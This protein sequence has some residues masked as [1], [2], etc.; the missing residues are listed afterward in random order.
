M[1]ALSVMAGSFYCLTNGMGWL[2]KGNG[3][4]KGWEM[5]ELGE[6]TTWHFIVLHIALE[7]RIG[8]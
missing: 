6:E 3:S 5:S 4:V 1:P 7:K 2:L 8:H